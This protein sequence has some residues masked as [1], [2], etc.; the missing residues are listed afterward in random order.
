MFELILMVDVWK[1]IDFDS[2]RDRIKLKRLVEMRMSWI[3][4]VS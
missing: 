3:A 4:K 2:N 1:V